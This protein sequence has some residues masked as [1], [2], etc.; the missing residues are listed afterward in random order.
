MKKNVVMAMV[1]LFKAFPK[2]KGDVNARNLGLLNSFNEKAIKHGL[3]VC[4]EAD[5]VSWITRDDLLEILKTYGIS[6]KER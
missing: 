4:P 5:L 1:R 3:F 2:T 6:T